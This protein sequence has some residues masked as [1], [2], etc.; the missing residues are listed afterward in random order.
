MRPPWWP[1]NSWNNDEP[2]GCGYRLSV[3]S[4]SGTEGPP[5]ADW[6]RGLEGRWFLL[7]GMARLQGRRAGRAPSAVLRPTQAGHTLF[8]GHP[9]SSESS[10]LGKGV[11]MQAPQPQGTVLGPQGLRRGDG[12]QARKCR[13][14]L[15]TSGTAVGAAVDAFQGWSR[16]A[17][18]GERERSRKPA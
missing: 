12:V 2:Q 11:G 10:H 9:R 15:G 8:P 13:P 18:R 6:R 3:S 5:G 4:G 16:G 7:E 17:P 14:G 1:R